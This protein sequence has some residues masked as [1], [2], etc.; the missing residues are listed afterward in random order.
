VST[1]AAQPQKRRLLSTITLTVT[2]LEDGT[3]TL[4]FPGRP[5]Y[6]LEPQGSLRYAV[7]ELP[8]FVAAF[9]RDSAGAISQMDVLQRPPQPNFSAIRV[10]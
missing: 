6:H 9:D 4:L 2:L 10:R 8:E 1:V 3:L 7:R 5:L